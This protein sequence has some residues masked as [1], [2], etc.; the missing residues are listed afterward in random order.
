MI[1]KANLK[2]GNTNLQYEIDEKDEMEALHKAIVLSE[3]PRYCNVCQNNQLFKLD[4]NKDKEGNCYVNV[5][6]KC[7]AK[8]KLGRYKAGGYFWH[9]FE[10]YEKQNLGIS[11]QSTEGKSPQQQIADEGK[12]TPQ[13]AQEEVDGWEPEGEG[14]PF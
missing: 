9:K 11:G 2:I 10:K 13:Q 12:I 4:S 6:C 3:V 14:V 8:A 1:I 5:R 7:G